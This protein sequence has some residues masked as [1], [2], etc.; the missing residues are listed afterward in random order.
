MGTIIS[1][2][3]TRALISRIHR[4]EGQLNAIERLIQSDDYE[5]NIIQLE[6]VFVATKALFK[7]YIE[8]ICASEQINIE[9]KNQL[10]NRLI[11]RR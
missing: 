3:Q 7:T 6:A 8:Q 9:T 10:L 2:K 1:D 4:I 11:N 5:K